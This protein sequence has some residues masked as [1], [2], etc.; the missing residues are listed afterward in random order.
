MIITKADIGLAIYGEITDEITRGN[1][2]LVDAKIAIGKGEVYGYLHRYDVDK[3]F[4]DDS[5]NDEFLKA[6]CINIIAWHLITLCSP[7]VNGDII[8]QNYEDAI[9]YLQ[10]VQKGTVR[11]DWPLRQDDPST[12][13]DDAGNIEWN[14]NPK[15]TNHY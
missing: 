5:W 6:L 11:P 4:T 7:N 8:R 1:E 2:S 15:R 12:P 10:N 13:I 9:S 14:S 3:I